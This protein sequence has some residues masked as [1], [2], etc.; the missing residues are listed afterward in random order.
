MVKAVTECAVCRYY[1]L[2]ESDLDFLDRNENTIKG[3][4][5]RIYF[6]KRETGYKAVLI[7][8][9]EDDDT[10]VGKMP[11]VSVGDTIE[12]TGSYID[13]PRFGIQFKADSYRIIPP[14]DSQAMERY[15]SSA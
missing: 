2:W 13:H 14:S 8:G 6:E 1:R 15:L 7:S 9:E 3:T 10:V 4:V 11:D 12:A 5:K